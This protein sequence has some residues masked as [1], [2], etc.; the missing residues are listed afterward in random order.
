MLGTL[1]GRDPQGF[2]VI[3]QPI[4]WTEGGWRSVRIDARGHT[5][6]GL[7]TTQLDG[8]SN[9]Q[10]FPYVETIFG[11]AAY[12]PYNLWERVQTIYLAAI[13]HTVRMDDHG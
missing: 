7:L 12:H 2:P 1:I 4:D 8:F 11:A 6:W 13:Y 5:D 3:I 9:R 10:D